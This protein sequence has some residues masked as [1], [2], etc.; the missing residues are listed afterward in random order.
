MKLSLVNIHDL[1]I[2]FK[3]VSES[4]EKEIVQE[5]FDLGFEIISR[6]RTHAS[7]QN[8]T[9]NLRSSFG[10]AVS[11]NGRILK[12]SYELHG[13]G[14]VGDGKDGLEAAKHLTQQIADENPNTI[15]LILVAA[16]GYAGYVERTGRS[17]LSGFIPSS[18]EQQLKLKV[19]DTHYGR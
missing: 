3:E 14:S 7:F 2:N 9:N 5:W 13:S 19:V 4:A 17:V 12:H 11:Q 18:I 16:E 6:C 10:V 8:W 1:L 15:V